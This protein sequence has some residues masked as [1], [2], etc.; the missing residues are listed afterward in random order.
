MK[1]NT[2]QPGD[3]LLHRVTHESLTF[4]QTFG[5]D[6]I[7]VTNSRDEIRI[8]NIKHVVLDYD[9]QFINYIK[10]SIQILW[11]KLSFRLSLHSRLT[12]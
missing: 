12:K 6:T 2:L 7:I 4:V 1:T 3:K 10:Q 5:D 8:Y 9:R 11:Q